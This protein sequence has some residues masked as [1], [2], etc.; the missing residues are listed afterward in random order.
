MCLLMRH[1]NIKSLSPF[2]NRRA[3]AKARWLVKRTSIFD[4]F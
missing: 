1:K 3:Y 4:R 2:G